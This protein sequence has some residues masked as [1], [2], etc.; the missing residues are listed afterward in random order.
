MNTNYIKYLLLVALILTTKISTA[1][2]IGSDG[3][4]SIGFGN[5]LYSDIKTTQLIVF[6]NIPELSTVSGNFSVDGDVNLELISQNKS[7]AMIAGFVPMFRYDL[8]LGL[9]ETFIKAGIGFNYINNHNINNRD[10]GGHFI[11]SDMI[12]I[13]TS[14]IKTDNFS[15]EISYLFRHISNA[16]FFH[17]NEGF[18]SQYLVVSVMI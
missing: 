8:D 15:A 16:G 2:S 3:D 4:L 10:L 7:T 5:G 17:S 1:Q 12:S 6:Y 9:M 14:L 13:G 11:F 18:N